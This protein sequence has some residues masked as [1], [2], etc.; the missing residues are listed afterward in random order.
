M[1]KM[2]MWIAI[3]YLACAM[4]SLQNTVPRAPDPHV[5]Q[6]L[7]SAAAIFPMEGQLTVATLVWS[8]FFIWPASQGQKKLSELSTKIVKHTWLSG[9]RQGAA[10]CSV[11]AWKYSK[12]FRTVL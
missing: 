3:H 6:H 1:T 8:L 4:L 12:Y 2:E 11:R 9:K 5:R 10:C 7:R